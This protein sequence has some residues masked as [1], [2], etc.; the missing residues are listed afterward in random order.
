MVRRVGHVVGHA[1]GSISHSQI[2]ADALASV[3]SL[4][5]NR[6]AVGHGGCVASCGNAGAAGALRGAGCGALLRLEVHE[7]DGGMV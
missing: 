6:E 1:I 5:D 7:L 2:V 4:T 3:P